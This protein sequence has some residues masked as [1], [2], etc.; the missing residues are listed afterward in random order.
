MATIAQ[1]ITELE[2]EL[3]AIKTA[4]TAALTGG[5]SASIDGISIS[6]ISYGALSDRRVEVE[7]S[8]QRLKRG[9]RGIVQD[10]SYGTTTT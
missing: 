8:L 10:L 3:A 9:G 5:Q 1:Q 6:R 7:K 4:Q 2:T